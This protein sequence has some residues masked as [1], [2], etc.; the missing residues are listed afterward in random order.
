VPEPTEKDGT[1]AKTL[2][3][4]KASGSLKPIGHFVGPMESVREVL[5]GK[6]GIDE[7][8]VRLRKGWFQKTLPL[9]KSE[10]GAIALLRLDGDWYESTMVCLENLYDNVV[11]GGYVVIDDY[12]RWEGCRKA[13]DEFLAKRGLSVKLV[14]VNDDIRYFVKP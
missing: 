6:V 4:E 13:V 8:Q 5:F 11:P 3:D 10:V 2:A 12:G 9:A 14:P 1:E 7:Q